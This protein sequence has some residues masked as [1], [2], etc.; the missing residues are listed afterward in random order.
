LPTL[1][2]FEFDGTTLARFLVG[3][4]QGGLMSKHL[5]L[6]VMLV[7]VAFGC[8]RKPASRSDDKTSESQPANQ[9]GS[10]PGNGAQG[11]PGNGAPAMGAP[12]TGAE[13]TPGAQ[14]MN[15]G[16]TT[17]VRVGSTALDDAQI[18][19]ITNNANTAEIEQGKLAQGRAKDSRVKQFADR[20]VKHHTEA[21]DKQ[22]KLKLNTAASDLS[23]KLERDAE[24]TLS[25]LKGASASSFDADYMAAQVT[26]HQDVLDTIDNKLL[27]NAKND[28]LKAY[29]KDIRPTVE[30]HLK[31]ARELQSKL[32]Q[33]ASR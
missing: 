1:S 18:A 26:E 23:T 4:V 16:A 27:P 2:R 28:D 33:A 25:D 8:D 10:A 7:A 15:S 21:K 19:Q 13:G 31:D 22:A 17:G 5:L 30:T 14:G 9:P 3:Q 29:L 12:T 11:T 20:M 32:N 6:P 24:K